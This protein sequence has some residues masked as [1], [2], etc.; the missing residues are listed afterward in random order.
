M[1]HLTYPPTR[2]SFWLVRS[3]HHEVR[4]FRPSFPERRSG[5][6]LCKSKLWPAG[7]ECQH[8]GVVAQAGKLK[9]KTTRT[10][11]WKCYACMK[12]F[13]VKVGTVFE[14]SHVPLHIWLQT[15][16][17][18]ASSKKGIST[19]Q[20]HR[21]MGVTLKTAWFHDRAYPGS[22]EGNRRFFTSRWAAHGAWWKATKPTSAEGRNRAYSKPPAVEPSKSSCRW[23]SAAAAS[24]ASTFRTSMPP[25]CNRS[26]RSM[27]TPIAAT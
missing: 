27:S 15:V 8:C 13:T 25:T 11:L 3:Q 22:D 21:T 7:P 1:F 19:H 4:I 14:S 5:L 6:R 9:G 17:L 10:G 20:I 12:P 23:L 18:I 24:A 16:H 26:S 2:C